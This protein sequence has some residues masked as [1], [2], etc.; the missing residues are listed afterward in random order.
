MKVNTARK[1]D[2]IAGLAVCSVLRVLHAVSPFKGRAVDRGVKPPNR[3][4]V[5]KCF[6]FGS[7][8]QMCP[9]LT[10][11]KESFPGVHITLLTFAE[12]AGVVRL[13]PAID[14]LVTV[15]F[16]RGFLR[17]AWDTLKSIRVLRRNQ[18]DAILACEF[19]SNYVAILAYLARR[20]GTMTIGFYR[21]G[22][23]RDWL[24]THMVAIDGSQ[25]VSRLFFKM[26]TPLGVQAPYHVLAECGI[27]PGPAAH[28]QVKGIL[29]GLGVHSGD[30]CVVMNVNASD[31]CL[32]RRWPRACFERLI[33]MLLDARPYGQCLRIILI[34]G[35]ADVEYVGGLCRDIA[36]P[37]VHDLAGRISI[38][39]LA[40]LLS[41]AD[42]FVGND[43][44]PLHLAVACGLRT[45]SFFGPETPHLY[46]PQG[47]RH[48]VLY[49]EQH[50]S[51]CLNVFYYKE[52]HC[53][54][55][56]CVQ[57][58]TPE[59]AFVAIDAMLREISPPGE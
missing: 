17:F 45:V 27:A 11:L 40:A 31:L 53:T 13:I 51:P 25:H 5:I 42:L 34:G 59:D 18:L 4:L 14:E 37:R 36:S 26:L 48:R 6:G 20:A 43:S 3:V 12:N 54:N 39:E 7:I 41:H 32:N 22:R 38:E 24:F 49:F 16:R 46:G 21:N 30:I 55:N 57:S 52:T 28:E 50:C 9:M 56:I 19:F 10:A 58:I 29:E 1:I 33:R 8:L 44:G 35:K 2:V 15:E 47:A 23:L